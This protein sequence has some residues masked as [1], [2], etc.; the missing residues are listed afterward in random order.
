MAGGRSKR[1]RAAL[2][3][4]ACA[5]HAHA[6]ACSNLGMVLVEQRRLEEGLDRLQ[7]AVAVDPKHA[8]ARI[9]LANT[10]HIDGQVDAALAH[11]LEAMRLAPEAP[12]TRVN[13]VKLLMDAC[14]WREVE[15]ITVELQELER[16]MFEAW[17]P[18]LQAVPGSVLWLMRSSQLAQRGDYCERRAVGGTAGA[19][20]SGR[21]AGIEGRCESRLRG[22][23]G[24]PGR[25]RPRRMRAVGN[26]SGARSSEACRGSRA[27]GAQSPRHAAFRHAPLRRQYRAGV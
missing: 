23:P 1:R 22:R 20:L 2:S 26:R 7:P 10:L 8:G 24:R 27:S 11:Y 9:N 3:R 12:E 21:D 19:H 15:L 18:M 4:C 13:V 17:M 6:A 25:A 14:Q 16:T 5:R